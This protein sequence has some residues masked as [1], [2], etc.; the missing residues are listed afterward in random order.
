VHY[1][2][3]TAT[4]ILLFLVPDA[5][6]ARQSDVELPFGLVLAPGRIGNGRSM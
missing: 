4:F 6:T 2:G 1:V 3:K 5:A